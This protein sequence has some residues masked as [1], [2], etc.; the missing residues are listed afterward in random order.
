VSATLDGYVPETKSV[1]RDQVEGRRLR[2][3]FELSPQDRATLVME[4]IPDVHHL[5]D[6]RFDGRIN[7]QF[8]KESEGDRYGT[9]FRLE[10]DQLPERVSEG[11]V[12]LLAKGV[13]RSHR[14]VINGETLDDRL[15]D[16][17]SDGSF[18]EF[19]A[20]FDISILREGENTLEVIAKPSSSDIDDFEFVNVR[21]RLLE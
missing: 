16:A 19:V 1:S 14:I 3:D 9:T 7:S 13:Q 11:E 21:V 17:P 12:V 10:S 2:V 18:G 8:Q 6:N 5:G 4:A 15:D 20:S